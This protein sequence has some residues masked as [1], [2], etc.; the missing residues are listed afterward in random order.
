VTAGRLRLLCEQT[1]VAQMD[2]KGQVVSVRFT[3]NAS[4]DPEK[5]M[6]LV[7]RNAKR[8][9]QFTPQGV[10]RFPLK[11]TTPSEVLV[12]L[13]RLVESVAMPTEPSTVTTGRQAVR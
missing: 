11:A 12:E 2:R 6:Q 8:G 5:L 7:A 1:G 10:L 9:A 13:R 4:I 3:E